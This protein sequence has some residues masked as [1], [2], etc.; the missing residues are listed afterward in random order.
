VKICFSEIKKGV[1]NTPFFNEFFVQKKDRK[2]EVK[3]K[4]IKNKNWEIGD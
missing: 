1:K 3:S 4:N 2:R